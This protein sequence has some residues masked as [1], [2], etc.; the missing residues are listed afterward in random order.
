MDLV[1]RLAD[2]VIVMKDGQII[3]E[4]VPHRLFTDDIHIE[5]WSLERP[6][7]CHLLAAVRSSGIPVSAGFIDVEEAADMIRRSVTDFV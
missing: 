1:A 3:A 4:D 2:R 6:I 7:L 5:K